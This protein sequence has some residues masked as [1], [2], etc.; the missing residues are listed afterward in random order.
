MIGASSSGVRVTACPLRMLRIV[1]ARS[2]GSASCARNAAVAAPSSTAS[3]DTRRRSASAEEVRVMEDRP[4]LRVLL[5][6]VVEAAAH[7]QRRE[8]VVHADRERVIRDVLLGALIG[9]VLCVD[10]GGR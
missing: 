1:V 6:D 8:P 9:G 7:G 4:S 5:P 2:P 3:A 10:V